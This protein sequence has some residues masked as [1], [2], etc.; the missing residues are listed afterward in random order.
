[1]KERKKERKKERE[2]ECWNECERK[3]AKGATCDDVIVP[4][5]LRLP[6]IKNLCK[7]YWEV[8]VKSDNKK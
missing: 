7:R 8:S 1:M 5:Q 6:C 2:N 3:P 4:K